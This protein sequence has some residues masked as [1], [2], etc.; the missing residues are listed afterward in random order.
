MAVKPHHEI[1]FCSKY[2]KNRGAKVQIMQDWQYIAF[3]FV[4]IKAFRAFAEHVG[5]SYHK[6]EDGRYYT[7][8]FLK[9]EYFWKIEEL[10]NGCKPLNDYCNGSLVKCYAH[11]EGDTITI[12][13]PNP[14]AEEVYTP[15]EFDEANKYRNNPLGV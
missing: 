2:Y 12:Y 7:D 10:P 14:N 4:T 11:K 1:Y 15:L 13:R 3:E 5:L 8:Q 6:D 9:N